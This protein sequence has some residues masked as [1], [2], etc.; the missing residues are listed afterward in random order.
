LL[1]PRAFQA[2][3]LKLATSPNTCVAEHKSERVP[4]LDGDA[5][6]FQ[7]ANERRRSLHFI[8]GD[9]QQ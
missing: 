4:L 8:L 5:Q 9:R 6:A 3:G 1:I 7:E 2:K